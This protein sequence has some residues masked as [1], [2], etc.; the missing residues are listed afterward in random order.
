VWFTDVAQAHD[1]HFL[2]QVLK[3]SRQG[4]LWIFDR[5]FYDVG[6]FEQVIARGA[7]WMTRSQSNLAYR[8]SQVLEQSDFIRDRLVWI[9]GCRY[10]LRLV[11][12]RFE[13]QWYRYLTRVVDPRVLPAEVVADLYRR[14]WRIEID[15]SCNLRK[16]LAMLKGWMKA[17][18]KCAAHFAEPV[19][20]RA[21]RHRPES[22]TGDV[23]NWCP[24]WP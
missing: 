4:T 6:F 14:H 16:T 9:E 11:E 2:E 18:A 7:A 17:I 1:T 8:V 22:A 23:S 24:A 20:V 15:Q 12:V 13:R 3:V 10:P 5:G 19:V 21:R